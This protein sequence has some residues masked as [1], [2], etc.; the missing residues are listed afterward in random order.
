MSTFREDKPDSY[1]EIAPPLTLPPGLD[2][3]T[4]EELIEV[5]RNARLLGK[6]VFVSWT[7]ARII[8]KLRE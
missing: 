4:K 2:D 1:V 5:A 8:E 7:R 3:M 6:T